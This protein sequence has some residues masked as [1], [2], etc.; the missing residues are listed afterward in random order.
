MDYFRRAEA[1]ETGSEH[2]SGAVE[3]ASW[4]VE[5]AQERHDEEASETHC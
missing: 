3:K 5:E 2:V 1:Q 4:G